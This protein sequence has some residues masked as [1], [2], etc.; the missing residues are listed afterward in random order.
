MEIN[1]NNKFFKY[2]WRFNAFVIAGAAILCILLGGFAAMKIFIDETRER[3]VTN[4]VNVGEQTKV[5]DKFVLGY[6]YTIEGTDYVR[7][8][9][10]RDESYDMS[11]YSK[12]R[13]GNEVN[14]L[15]MNSGNG[16]NKW[17]MQAT[18]QLFIS[19]IVLLEKLKTS[20]D[21][22]NKAVGVVYALVEKDT[23]GDNRLSD[24]DAITIGTSSLDGSSYKK[25]I[26]NIDRLYALKQIADNKVIVLY[27][28]NKN[29]MS[30]VYEVPSMKK[31][32]GTPIP[33]VNLE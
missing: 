33:K 21:E 3:H 1:D 4:V 28:K 29:T 2:V 9:L 17:L 31:V 12:S 23:N 13:G 19:D 22:N 27:Q 5:K 14:Y 30:E 20:R 26:E 24:K 32:S 15:F 25:L 6:P 18:N 8:P 16:E 7:V 11:Y 10:Y